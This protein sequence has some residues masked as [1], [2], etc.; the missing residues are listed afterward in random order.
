MP[1]TKATLEVIDI[2]SIS[3]GLANDFGNAGGILEYIATQ[4]TDYDVDIRLYIDTNLGL[5]QDQITTISNNLTSN[6]IT[7]S[8]GVM[9]KSE[10][11]AGLQ[12]IIASRNNLGIYPATTSTQGLISIGIDTEYSLSGSSS[13]AATPQGVAT[14]V[15]PFITAIDLSIN[16]LNNTT[17]K[18]SNNLS[19]YSGNA[20][21]QT[22]IRNNLGIVN[23]SAATT[24]TSGQVILASSTDVTHAT[25]T[26]NTR[27]ITPQLL[28]DGTSV[29]MYRNKNV[30]NGQSNPL[31][32]NG[33]YSTYMEYANGYTIC[34]VKKSLIGLSY[35]YVIDFPIE[36]DEIYG[37][38]TNLDFSALTDPLVDTKLISINVTKYNTNVSSK[39]VSVDTI[40]IAESLSGIERPLAI[41][42]DVFVV[43]KVIGSR[44]L[45]V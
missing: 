31:N 17:L 30:T 44:G 21:A 40:A 1:L 39:Y 27:V 35:P 25:G 11:L 34:T 10:N 33:E 19:E 13:K 6:G 42:D 4:I 36:L 38:T 29:F 7:S 26:N 15:I 14:Y 43:L 28:K 12:N 32:S 18:I 3:D 23:P 9:N 20:I 37:V 16:T 2:S 41:N 45:T 22:A 8:V 24:S 5:L